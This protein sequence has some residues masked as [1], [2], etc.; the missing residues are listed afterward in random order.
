M[1]AILPIGPGAVDARFRETFADGSA[2]AAHPRQLAEEAPVAFEFDG[3]AHAVMMAT[4]TDLEDFARG[5]A[6]AEGLLPRDLTFRWIE[7]AE[8][9]NGWIVPGV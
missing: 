7:A 5:F 6:I 2:P 3:Q 1:N 9:P 8:T 4:P